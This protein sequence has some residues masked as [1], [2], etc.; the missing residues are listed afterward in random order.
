MQKDRGILLVTR[1]DGKIYDNVL[2]S[3]GDKWK[4]R[5]RILTPAFSANKMRMV[6]LYVSVICEYGS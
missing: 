5:R 4:K 3:R 1:F 2:A 6:S